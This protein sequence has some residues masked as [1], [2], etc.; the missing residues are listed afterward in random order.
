MADTQTPLERA[1]PLLT[2]VLH[3]WNLLETFHPDLPE[4][5]LTGAGKSLSQG[6]V[7]LEALC[8]A[9][10]PRECWGSSWLLAAVAVQPGPEVE[11]LFAPQESVL[12]KLPREANAPLCSA[13]PMFMEMP[14]DKA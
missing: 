12:G 8:Y 4:C 10:A 7:F 13:S 3:Q 2:G 14:T 1:Q 9:I 5:T 6:R 11:T